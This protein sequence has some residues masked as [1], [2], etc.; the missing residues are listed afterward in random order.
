MI[1]GHKSTQR[2]RNDLKQR[3][4]GKSE[5]LRLISELTNNSPLHA[6]MMEEES[7]ETYLTN[8]VVLSRNLAPPSSSHE[9]GHPVWNNSIN[10]PKLL[11]PIHN[12]R[13]Y[14]IQRRL[15]RDTIDF[16]TK[17]VCS[18]ICCSLGR[19]IG[20]HRSVQRKW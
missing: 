14:K 8:F 6:Y 2:L 4:A 20:I 12:V 1:T 5:L 11:S 18:V 3:G 19:Y 7:R 15:E 17:I 10:T 16:M 9:I 13:E